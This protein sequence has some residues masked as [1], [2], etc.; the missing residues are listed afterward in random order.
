MST[1]A[2]GGRYRAECG[3]SLR[4]VAETVTLVKVLTVQL[5]I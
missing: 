5:T 1:T 4:C 2:I 3:E